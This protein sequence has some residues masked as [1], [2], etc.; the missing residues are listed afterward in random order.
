[1][2]VK[3]SSE[4]VKEI[5]KETD[6]HAPINLLFAIERKELTYNE[7]NRTQAI[8]YYLFEVIVKDKLHISVG[9][10]FSS[11]NIYKDLEKLR[12]ELALLKLPM[13]KPISLKGII[14]EPQAVGTLFHEFAHLL[15]LDRFSWKRR[16]IIGERIFDRKDLTV[17]EKPRME[18]FGFN[19]ITDEGIETEDVILVKDGKVKEPIDSVVFRYNKGCCGYSET[20]NELALPR[21]VN[22]YVSIDKGEPRNSFPNNDVAIIKNVVAS[23]ANFNPLNVLLDIT[24]IQGIL[25]KDNKPSGIFTGNI[26]LRVALKHFIEDAIFSSEKGGKE[27]GFCIKHGQKVRSTQTAPAALLGKTT[28]RSFLQAITRLR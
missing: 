5:L 8:A 19:M 1:M 18:S 10:I 28:S 3:E 11:K 14:L 13:V 22:L 17:I 24:R 15:E 26:N 2:N 7:A 12:E 21:T 9:N 4:R 23:P 16:R 6:L 20:A 25:L 27:P